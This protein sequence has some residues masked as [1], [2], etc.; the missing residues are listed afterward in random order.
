MAARRRRSTAQRSRI[1]ERALAL[2]QSYRQE[3]PEPPAP[4]DEASVPAV[5]PPALTKPRA[6]GHTSRRRATARRG[7]RSDKKAPERSATVSRDGKVAITCPRCKAGYR[8]PEEF[9]EERVTCKHCRAVFSP[10]IAL[11]Q[12]QKQRRAGGNSAANAVGL[13]AVWVIGFVVLFLVVWKFIPKA[14]TPKEPEALVIRP[15]L[16]MRSPMW[17]V[18]EDFAGAVHNKNRALVISSVDMEWR[19]DRTKKKSDPLFSFI[20]LEDKKALNEALYT[21]L[22]DS[23]DGKIFREW[24]PSNP[25]ELYLPEGDFNQLTF[26]ATMLWR[27][28][29]R[30][31][32]RARV[33]IQVGRDAVNNWKVRE[34]KTQHIPRTKFSSKTGRKRGYHKKLGKPE[35]RTYVDSSGKKKTMD[36]IKPQPLDHLADTPADVRRAIDNTLELLGDPELPGSELSQARLK[37]EAIGIPAL[38]RLLTK[39][40]TIKGKNLDERIALRQIVAVLRS[41]TGMSFG[42]N[43]GAASDSTFG[44]TDDMR[45]KALGGWFGWYSKF[46]WRRKNFDHN[47]DME[48]EDFDKIPGRTGRRGRK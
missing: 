10:K 19:Y 15:M 20:R 18:F 23:D 45:E 35:K 25:E 4:T 3:N 9:L 34:F 14:E 44:S 37:L 6:G 24:E 22:F 30:H 8:V 47:M 5:S 28:A 21:R 41:I 27:E 38:P 12:E 26:V 13:W 31:F 17:R 32:G 42:Y 40:Y 11:H 36:Y 2:E 48:E 1:K 16:S 46:G 43:P 39:F 7:G 29:G 33:E